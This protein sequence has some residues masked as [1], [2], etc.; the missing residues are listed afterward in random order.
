MAQQNRRAIAAGRWSPPGQGGPSE[1][2]ISS[3]ALQADAG[4]LAL[5]YQV[6]LIVGAALNE[7]VAFFAG[8]AYLIEKHPIALGL[9]VLLL[10]GLVVRFPT[11][12]RVALWIDRQQEQLIQERQAG[13]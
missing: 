3:A 2:Q 1:G 12:R 7:G 11:S 5:V 4:K 8:I 13:F 10:A 9:A 6:Q